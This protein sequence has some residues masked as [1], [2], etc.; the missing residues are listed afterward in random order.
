MGAAKMRNLLKC[1][2][3]LILR[4]MTV[5]VDSY[6]KNEMFTIP[7]VL[8]KCLQILTH[9]IYN[10]M[11]YFIEERLNKLSKD[12]FCTWKNQ[13][14]N[15][16]SLTL[17]SRWL[18]PVLYD[19]PC[20]LNIFQLICNSTEGSLSYDLHCFSVKMILIFIVKYIW[21]F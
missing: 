5:K 6:P 3:S 18:A 21:L 15:L 13:E 10:H 14:S 17:Q 11:S 7:Q 19:S 2:G 8:S 4:R 1:R 16:E 9:S 20:G 12:Q